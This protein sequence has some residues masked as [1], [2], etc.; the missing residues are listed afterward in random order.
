MITCSFGLFIHGYLNT[1]DYLQYKVRSQVSISLPKSLKPPAISFC[2][3]LSYLIIP[4]KLKDVEMK[5]YVNHN[6]SNPYVSDG[7]HC[8]DILH[9]YSMSDIMNLMTT[10]YSYHAMREVETE[11]YYKLGHKCTKF[12]RIMI[13]QERLT[14]GDMDKLE[15]FPGRLVHYLIFALNPSFIS[16]IVHDSDKLSYSREGN[17]LLT[18]I[19][20][21]EPNAMITT[22]DE[23]ETTY[24]RSPFESD[25]VSYE[26]IGAFVTRGDCFEKC[27]ERKY[28]SNFQYKDG[29]ITTTD[30]TQ[31][32]SMSSNSKYNREIDMECDKLCKF[33]CKTREYFISIV[34]KYTYH[35]HNFTFPKDDRQS[36][37]FN[38]LS[39]RPFFSVILLPSTDFNSYIIFMASIAG[40]WLGSSLYGSVIN[41]HSFVIKVIKSK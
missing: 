1:K 40:L 27:Y 33:D 29:F 19:A 8:Q 15:I 7:H 36:Y 23:I 12:A 32:G 9:N 17:I 39:S 31:V 24:L 13:N 3:S 34:E 11:N 20:P 41:A 16:L 14:S 28:D 37:F 22:Y 10:N 25:C 38:L 26:K 6:C 18:F 35:N 2:Q 30:Y 21:Q 4:E 5:D